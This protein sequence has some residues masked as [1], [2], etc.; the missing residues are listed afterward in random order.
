MKKKLLSVQK[1]LIL[2]YFLNSFS[3]FSFTIFLRIHVIH[4]QRK[5][6]RF[7]HMNIIV[8]SKRRTTGRYEKK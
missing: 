7:I 4:L 8:K 5:K 1:T 2:R 6:G 3:D